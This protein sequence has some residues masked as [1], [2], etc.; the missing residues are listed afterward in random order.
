MGKT[1]KYIK[2][3]VVIQLLF[4]HL[5]GAKQNQLI[6]E[7]EN[8]KCSGGYNNPKDIINYLKLCQVYIEQMNLI[9]CAPDKKY[10][11]IHNTK[12]VLIVSSKIP[13]TYALN[14]IYGKKEGVLLVNPKI[15]IEVATRCREFI[16]EISRISEG[17]KGREDK[18]AKLFDY[19]LSQE[20]TSLMASVYQTNE[21]MRSLQD[22]E[23]KIHMRWW[24]DRKKLRDQLIQA[25]MEIETGV[26]SI[27]QKGLDLRK[28][29][30]TSK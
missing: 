4:G 6:T 17:K 8:L 20:F 13:K 16:L 26:E 14:G 7:L 19:V 10:Q 1:N 15:I 11:Q 22:Q 3:G 21:K 28:L 23:E 9:D 18:E 25:Y 12:Y 30:V 24:K 27:T 29:K 2:A 5:S